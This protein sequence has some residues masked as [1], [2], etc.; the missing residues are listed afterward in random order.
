MSARAAVPR[1]LMMTAF[2]FARLRKWE[3]RKK[4]EG[5]QPD[6]ELLLYYSA[7]SAP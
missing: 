1:D 3:I 4:M 6:E 2:I 5:K 7:V